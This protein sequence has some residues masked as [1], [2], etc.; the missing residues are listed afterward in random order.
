MYELYQIL[1]YLK[2][3]GGLLPINLMDE[4]LFLSTYYSAFFSAGVEKV[5]LFLVQQTKN[6]KNSAN[7]LTL[8]TTRIKTFT[9]STL[10]HSSENVLH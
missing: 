9:L 10:A 5:N 6:K 2:S 7:L 1:L 8:I 3:R 4:G